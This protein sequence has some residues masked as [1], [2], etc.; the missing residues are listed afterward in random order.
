MWLSTGLRALASFGF[1]VAALS[2]STLFTAPAEAARQCGGK[3]AMVAMYETSWCPYCKAARSFLSRAGIPHV[4]YDI[5][6]SR[7]RAAELA[8]RTG[9]DG[10]PAFVACGQVQVGFG[11]GTKAWLREFR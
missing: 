2:G 10:V 9:Q 7:K 3:R 4:T 5:E 1:G 6:R 11:E 8:R